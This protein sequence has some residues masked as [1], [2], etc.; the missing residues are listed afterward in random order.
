M[1]WDGII[2]RA[3]EGKSVNELPANFVMSPLGSTAEIAAV[4]QH[5][6]PHAAHHRGQCCVQGDDYWLELNFGYPPDKDI[7]DS[8]GVRCNAG[9]GV[10][11]VLQQVCDAFQARLF[12]NQTG[13]FADLGAE[14]HASLNAFAEWRGRVIESAQGTGVEH[15]NRLQG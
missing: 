12:D 10:V 5:V 7:R 8:I 15:E 13:E 11:P 14:T 1:S 9:P 6:F 3:P 4:L 2:F